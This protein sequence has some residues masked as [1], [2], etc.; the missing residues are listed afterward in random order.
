MR[1]RQVSNRILIVDDDQACIDI[2][3]AGLADVTDEVHGLTDSRNVE[4]V[5]AEFAPDLV[6]VDMHM[7]PPDGLEVLR[8]LRSAR[9][10]LGYLPVI[11]LTA[12]TSRIVRNSA[13]ILGANDFLTKPFDRWEVTLR[14]RN[15]LHTRHLYEELRGSK[16]P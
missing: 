12:D 4:F 14:C 8:M 5:F 10:S 2:L 1:S 15:L 7:P 13:L 6:L 11:M 3:A 9:E 16:Q